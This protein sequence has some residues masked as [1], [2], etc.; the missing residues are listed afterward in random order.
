MPFGDGMARVFVAERCEDA[1]VEWVRLA[2]EWRG[3][4]KLSDS[5]TCRSFGCRR[6]SEHSPPQ[7]SSVLQRTRDTTCETTNNECSLSLV[8]LYICLDLHLH[9]KH[10]VALLHIPIHA[11]FC[12][13]HCYGSVRDLSRDANQ[14]HRRPTTYRGRSLN[15]ALRCSRG[16]FLQVQ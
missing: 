9:H 6:F 14:H 11:R 12:T 7:R 13:Q 1:V 15:L 2:M 4:V 3:E 10:Q 8:V 5:Q 16:W